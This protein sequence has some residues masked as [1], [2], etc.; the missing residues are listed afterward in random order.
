MVSAL[1]SPALARARS[2]RETGSPQLRSITAPLW[3]GDPRGQCVWVK[4]WLAYEEKE[5][6]R[7]AGARDPWSSC[8]EPL[9]LPP[10]F[11]DPKCKHCCCFETGS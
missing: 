3:E 6:M 2:R 9:H 10:C 11:H 5:I 8:L 7:S 4:A 1:Q